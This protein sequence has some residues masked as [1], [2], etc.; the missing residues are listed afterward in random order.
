MANF[1]FDKS[2][3]LV[4]VD[5]PDK[6]VTCQEIVNAVRNWSD[7]QGNMEVETFMFPSG[8]ESLDQ[9]TSVGITVRFV[10]WK[11]KFADRA[12][13]E[14]CT[15]RGGN[16]IGETIGGVAQYPI[17]SANY[18]N[19]LIAQSSSATA[20][21]TGGSALTSEEHNKL[22][23]GLDAS[24][25]DNVWDELKSE[26]TTA[27]TYGDYLDQKISTISGVSVNAGEIADAVWDEFVVD[28]TTSGSFGAMLGATYDAH[29]NKKVL[30][31]ISDTEYKEELYDDAGSVVIRT[32]RLVKVGDVETREP[33]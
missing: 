20:I 3:K 10:V 31:K 14:I 12:D 19:A 23:T 8:K 33:Q 32:H 1:T 2:N 28:H 17:E 9:E 26:H 22:I 6:E 16:F 25:P 4:I 30:T 21:A 27:D 15:I 18:V 13:W 5:L 7:N 29:W 11:L 24:I